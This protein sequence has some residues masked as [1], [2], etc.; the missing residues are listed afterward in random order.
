MKGIPGAAGGSLKVAPRGG[1]GIRAG[2]WL[3]VIG[4]DRRRDGEDHGEDLSIAQFRF[5]A[6]AGEF[7]D[8]L[9]D[10]KAESSAGLVEVGGA[11]LPAAF[12][13]EG[14]GR[15]LLDVGG[16]VMHSGEVGKVLP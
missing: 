3:V 1:A 8:G 16:G 7:E 14:A 6:D 10:G 5:D 12:E 9:G 2:F 13:E 11:F 15:A 4:L